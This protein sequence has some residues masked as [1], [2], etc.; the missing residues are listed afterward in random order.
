M[1]Y[2]TENT[3]KDAGEKIDEATRQDATEKIES[4]RK[5]VTTGEASEI[6]SAFSI[7][8][9]ASHSI[10]EKLYAANDAESAQ[11]SQPEGEEVIDA[12]FNEEK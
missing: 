10:A 3:L 12:E 2:Q 6:Q 11:A 9:Q 1:A 7:L 4:L 8:E 5:A